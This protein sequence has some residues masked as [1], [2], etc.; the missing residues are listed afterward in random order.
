MH[1][2]FHAPN[3]MWHDIFFPFRLFVIAVVTAI[4]SKVVLCCASM[5][6]TRCRS[7]AFQCYSF[8]NRYFFFFVVVDIVRVIP[9]MVR[10]AEAVDKTINKLPARETTENRKRTQIVNV[11]Y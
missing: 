5:G 10:F 4:Q 11:K 6:T 9:I 8:F 7:G 1:Y 3:A 2:I